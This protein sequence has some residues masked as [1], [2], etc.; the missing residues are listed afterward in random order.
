MS[1]SGVS[2]KIPRRLPAA[3][4]DCVAYWNQF[5][6]DQHFLFV[7]ELGGRLNVNYLRQALRLAMDAEPIFGCRLMAAQLRPYWE[8]RDDLDRLQLCDVIE[9]CDIRQE[10]TRFAARECDAAVDPLVQ[11]CILRGN[12]DTLCVK[13][14]HA[15]ADGAGAKEL[16]R[17]IGSFYRGLADQQNDSLLNIVP[18]LGNRGL[19]Q[20]LRQ[21]DLRQYWETFR[22]KARKPVEG[23]WHFPS[24]DRSDRTRLLLAMRRLEPARFDCLK[25]RAQR[26]G[27]TLNDLFLAAC[28]RSFWKFLNFPAGIPQS[29]FVPMN[30]RAFLPSGQTGAIC[31]F[32]LPTYPRLERIPGEPFE[33]TVQRAKAEMPKGAARRQQALSLALAISLGHSLAPAGMKK[34]FREAYKKKVSSGDTAVTFTN[35]GVLEAEKLD[36]GVLVDDAWQTHPAA[37]AADLLMGVVSF[38]KKMTFTLSYPSR[39]LNA[40]DIERFFDAFIEELTMEDH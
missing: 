33:R 40:E 6:L 1:K 10:V 2:V 7:L 31:N 21:A 11:A 17:L 32:V 19:W 30:A 35:N 34:M 25:A 29:I 9:S 12:T 22:R 3:A 24:A 8:R 26:L 39:A 13:V 38:R 14:N 36:F 28:F 37:F 23:D 20:L 15:A 18:N 27:A 4:L 16:L 5:N